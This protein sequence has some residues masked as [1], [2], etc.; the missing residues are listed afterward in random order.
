MTQQEIETLRA[1][2]LASKRIKTDAGEVE[3]R[4]VSELKE[5]MKLLDELDLQASRKPSLNRLGRYRRRY[6]DE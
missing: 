3:E 2:L 5:A 4:S 1:A 6:N